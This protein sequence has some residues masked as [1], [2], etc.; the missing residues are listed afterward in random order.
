MLGQLCNPEGYVMSYKAIAQQ[1]LKEHQML[2]LISQAM[3]V[4]IGWTVPAH[5]MS[6]KLSSLRFVAESLRRH[7]ERLMSLEEDGGYLH[8]VVESNPNLA[9]KVDALR[10]DHEKFRQAWSRI[11]PRLDKVSPTEHA[12]LADL[13]K[14]LTGLLHEIQEHSTTETTLVQEAILRDEGGEG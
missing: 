2:K 10:L 11:L 1:V 14:E 6:R 4:A 13:C 12:A 8:A 3:Q 5:E 9:S 7:Q